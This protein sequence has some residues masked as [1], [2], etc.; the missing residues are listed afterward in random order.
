MSRRF[1][2]GAN[3]GTVNDEPFTGCWVGQ[4]RP[5]GKDLENASALKTLLSG[6]CLHQANRVD[7]QLSRRFVSG[8]CMEARS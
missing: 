6:C 7:T 5:D 1:V 4:S 3:G 2:G 8:M